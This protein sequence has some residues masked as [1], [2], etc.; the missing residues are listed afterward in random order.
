MLKQIRERSLASRAG[1]GDALA[2]GLVGLGSAV[3][4]GLV[5]VVAMPLRGAQENGVR[6]EFASP[7]E[8]GLVDV[9]FQKGFLA[10]SARGALSVVLKP[11][12]GALELVSRAA[13]GALVSAG[14]GSFALRR[15]PP[16]KR[17][18]RVVLAELR[19]R[20][21]LPGFRRAFDCAEALVL[22]TTDEALFVV[23][24]VVVDRLPLAENF[25]FQEIYSAGS[26]SF[27]LGKWTLTLVHRSDRREFAQAFKK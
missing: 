20:R 10:G 11:L 6:G 18:A 27:K 24:D 13:H 5:G 8:G 15:A 23:R 16:R 1:L 12:G 21:K 14:G 7:V 25:V 4:D 9:V 26:S 17:R 3:L 19:W 22:L 2:T